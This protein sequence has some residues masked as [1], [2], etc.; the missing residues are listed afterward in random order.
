MLRDRRCSLV[1]S[2]SFVAVWIRPIA[3]LLCLI[4]ETLIAVVGLPA[5]V[6]CNDMLAIC[7]PLHDFKSLIDVVEYGKGKSRIL[8]TESIARRRISTVLWR[9][10][11]LVRS[12]EC[13][14]QLDTSLE[15]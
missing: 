4:E 11:R 13:C 14:R 1:R 6:A 12:G 5:E 15:C 2:L 3:A 9:L 7:T 8:A 10:Q